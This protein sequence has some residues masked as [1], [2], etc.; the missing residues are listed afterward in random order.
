ML[1]TSIVAFLSAMGTGV[2]MISLRAT[3]P[4]IF[5]IVP[6]CYIIIII[7]LG[8]VLLVTK[9]PLISIILVGYYVANIIITAEI[10]RASA[11]YLGFIFLP[12][13]LLG[14]FGAFRY[15][16]IRKRDVN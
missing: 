5:W 11:S 14:I 8:I 7:I 1:L 12:I 16:A 9:L 10:L 3:D 2:L 13:L 15:Q 6:I 4:I